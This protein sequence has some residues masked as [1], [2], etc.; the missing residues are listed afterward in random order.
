[1]SNCEFQDMSVN[2]HEDPRLRV[3][4]LRRAGNADVRT[5]H[6]SDIHPCLFISVLER[7]TGRRIEMDMT[8]GGGRG[9]WMSEL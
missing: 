4:T 7:K 6:D 5:E 9:I 3:V 2:F 8:L 1:M